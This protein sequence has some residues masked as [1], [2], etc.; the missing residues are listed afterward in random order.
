MSMTLSPPLAA[1]EPE[2][3]KHHWT[4]D[5]FY[6]AYDDGLLD[7]DKRWELLQGRIVEKMIPGPRHSYFADA[8]AH[9]LRVVLEPP[10][11]VREEKS[12]RLTLDTELIP[13]VS[14]VQGT[15]DDYRERHPTPIDIVLI[16]EVAD[17]SVAKD[18]GEKAQSYSQAGMTEYWVVLVDEEAIVVHRQPTLDGY[19]S[20]LRLTETNSLSPLAMPDITWTINELLGRTEAQ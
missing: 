13:D 10:L 12:V 17:S 2:I 14:V 1:G 9:E 19:Q 3:R 20:V 11:L 4:V 18:L 6:Q 7:N 5:E 8:I 15:R 16:V